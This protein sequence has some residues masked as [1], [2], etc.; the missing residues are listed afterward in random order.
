MATNPKIELRNYVVD[1][2]REVSIYMREHLEKV[3]ASDIEEKEL[4]SLVSY[5]DKEVEKMIVDKL[6]QVTPDAGLITEED[7][8]N[9]PDK[10]QVWII[11]PLDGTTNFLRKIPHFSTSIALMENGVITLGVVYET[12]HDTAYAAIRGQGAWMNNKPISV[13]QVDKMN[14]AIVV[15]GFP[16]RRDGDMQQSLDLIQFCVV[17]CRGI[18]RLGSAALDLAYIA[19]GKLDIYYENFLNIWDIAAGVL[20]VEEAGGVLTDFN[21]GNQYLETG[22]IIASNK[23]LHPEISKAITDTYADSY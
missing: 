11:D 6:M 3:E 2:C 4:N 21:N 23:H 22:G 1:L 14:K 10:A 12:M 5:V 9:D 13:S 7:T 15:T 17:N 16:Y 18:R 20:L 19:S 8:K